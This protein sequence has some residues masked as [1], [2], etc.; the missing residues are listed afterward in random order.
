MTKETLAILRKMK[1]P[2]TGT[3]SNLQ[4][5]DGTALYT[6]V[7]ECLTWPEPTLSDGYYSK[8]LADKGI[9]KVTDNQGPY[10]EVDLTVSRTIPLNSDTLGSLAP[11]VSK[12]ETRYYMTGIYISLDAPERM[13]ST[14]GHRLAAPSLDLA[15]KMDPDYIIL[16]IVPAL[17]QALKESPTLGLG[18]DKKEAYDAH[19]ASPYSIAIKGTGWTYGYYK[20]IEAQFPNF[21]RVIPDDSAV[22][23]ILLP[24]KEILD[25]WAKLEPFSIANG[26]CV[27]KFDCDTWTRYL[28]GEPVGTYTIDAPVTF[29][30]AI[31][32]RYVQQA[33]KDG[34]TSL[35]IPRETAKRAT[36][37]IISSALFASCKD[38]EAILMPKCWD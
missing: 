25:T 17:M 8:A 19:N 18:P 29:K 30:L 14:D 20:T 6:N 16:P 22:D 37:G 21:P 24:P 28:K 11:Y 4:V 33:A 32:I 38:Y 9:W 35:G 5:K 36:E 1:A 23:S 31:N 7:R 34:A 27:L 26:K 3:L 13:I 10:P 2:K 15:R 12:D